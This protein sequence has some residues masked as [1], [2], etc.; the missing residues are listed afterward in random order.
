MVLSVHGGWQRQSGEVP[1]RAPRRHHGGDGPAGRPGPDEGRWLPHV[2]S[3]CGRGGRRS[4]SVNC[5]GGG[6]GAGDGAGASAGA[7]AGAGAGA[8]LVLVLVLSAMGWW[9]E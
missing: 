2:R 5:G 1:R 6:A 4:V 8:V 3:I 9:Y 7:G